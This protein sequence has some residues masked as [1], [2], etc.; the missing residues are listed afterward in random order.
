MNLRA[1]W[2]GPPPRAGDYLMSER[3]PRYAYR[4]EDV[5]HTSSQVCWN[6]AAKVET[7]LLKFIVARVPVTSVPRHARIHPWKWDRREA[8][9]NSRQLTI[10][11][12]LV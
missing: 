11:G 2:H 1:R 12:Q 10:R 5:E 4:I 6:P 8:K 3:R 9:Y 7:H